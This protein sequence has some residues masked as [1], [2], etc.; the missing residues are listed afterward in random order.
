MPNAIDVFIVHATIKKTKD[1][2][3][4]GEAFSLDLGHPNWRE[5]MTQEELD[6]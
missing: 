4:D 6:L 5:T 1:M 3:V 2:V